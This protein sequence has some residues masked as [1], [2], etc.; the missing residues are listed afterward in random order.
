YGLR[1][2]LKRLKPDALPGAVRELLQPK[3][4]Q[5]GGPVLDRLVVQPDRDLNTAAVQSVLALA[6]KSTAKSPEL[7]AEAVAKLTELAQ[8]HPRDLSV[9]TAA[10]LAALTEDKPERVAEAVDRLWA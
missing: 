7:R 3:A 10:A 1:R 4:E 8:R 6:L 5:K 9:L 2:T